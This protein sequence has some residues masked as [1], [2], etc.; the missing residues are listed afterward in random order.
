MM[1]KL[2]SISS[3]IL[4]YCSKNYYLDCHKTMHRYL[5]CRVVRAQPSLPRDCSDR[6]ELLV[7]GKGASV[8]SS[9]NDNFH[10]SPANG[11]IHKRS[12]KTCSWF[13]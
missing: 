3:L 6:Y 8:L 2:I 13:N 10:L 7:R 12:Q 11:V 4:F 1:W 9:L 5:V